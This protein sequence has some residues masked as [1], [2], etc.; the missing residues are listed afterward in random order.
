MTGKRVLR[1]LPRLHIIGHDMCNLHIS[2][3]HGLGLH[4]MLPQERAETLRSGA[5][6]ELTSYEGPTFRFWSP[7][8]LL[9]TAFPPQCG[10]KGTKWSPTN[11]ATHT[12]PDSARDSNMAENTSFLQCYFLGHSKEENNKQNDPIRVASWLL[13]IQKALTL[14][15][16]RMPLPTRNCVF[17]L[18]KGMTR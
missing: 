7:G 14:H 16:T 18:Q 9:L 11:K 15:P 13:S 4:V 17:V 8:P 3:C 2:V 1:F 10:C 5:Y 6:A 12:V